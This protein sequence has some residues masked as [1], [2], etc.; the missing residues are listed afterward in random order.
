MDNDTVQDWLDAKEII[1]EFIRE[2]QR[3]EMS[4]SDIDHNAAGL[5]ARLACKNLLIVNAKQIKE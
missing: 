4:E 2:L 1:K 5:I 3:L